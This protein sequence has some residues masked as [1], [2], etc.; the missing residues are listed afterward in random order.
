LYFSEASQKQR[1]QNGQSFVGFL[2]SCEH[3]TA[4]RAS[5]SP[6]QFQQVV[7]NVS[8]GTVDPWPLEG[9]PRAPTLDDN[10]LTIKALHPLT[11]RDGV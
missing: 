1:K 5:N 3:Q 2:G 9:E 11:L 8:T 7:R 6:R 10:S 4:F